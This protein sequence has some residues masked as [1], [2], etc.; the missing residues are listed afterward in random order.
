MKL[1]KRISEIFSMRGDYSQNIAAIETAVQFGSLRLTDKKGRAAALVDTVKGWRSWTEG[2][3]WIQ[4]QAYAEDNKMPFETVG[5][6]LNVL[7]SL[8]VTK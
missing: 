2:I 3:D 1:M 6:M 4:L 5:D 8:N 7:K